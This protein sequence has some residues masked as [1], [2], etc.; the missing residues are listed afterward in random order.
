[1]KLGD[2][3][4]KEVIKRYHK[5][6]DGIECERCAFYGGCGCLCDYL[7]CKEEYIKE[8][9][10]KLGL[11]ITEDTKI[12]D[13]ILMLLEREDVE[14]KEDEDFEPPFDEDDNRLTRLL[15]EMGDD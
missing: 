4:F 7:P 2:M 5:C 11:G 14:E 13:I 10:E 12:K 3:T 1:M 8:A 9:N 6:P 15:N